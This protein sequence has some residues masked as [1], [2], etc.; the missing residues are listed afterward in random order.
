[1]PW[2]VITKNPVL[3]QAARI[4]LIIASHSGEEGSER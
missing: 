4:C 3:K 1:M 2:F